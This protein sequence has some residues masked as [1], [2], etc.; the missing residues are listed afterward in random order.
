MATKEAIK[1]IKDQAV[2][3][4]K[5]RTEDLYSKNA[6][7]KEKIVNMEAKVEALNDVVC[8]ECKQ[9]E[10]SNVELLDKVNDMQVVLEQHKA[11]IKQLRDR[12]GI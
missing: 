2:Q 10:S 3:D 8:K 12:I 5:A 6:I 7:L 11:I 1:N 9:I 4:H